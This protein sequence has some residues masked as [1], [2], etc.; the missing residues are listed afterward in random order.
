MNART[1]VDRWGRLSAC[2]WLAI[3]CQA[4]APTRK[5]D[6]KHDIAPLLEKYCFECHYPGTSSSGI[7]LTGRK[8][9]IASGNIIPGKPT[10][11][12]FYN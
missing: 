9:L 2:L 6:F 12:F 10:K 5:I 7:E 4:S 1:K 11:S 3:V 8:E